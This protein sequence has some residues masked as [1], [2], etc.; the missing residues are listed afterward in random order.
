MAMP[1]G[2]PGAEVRSAS[3]RSPRCCLSFKNR[4]RS[5]CR[6]RVL[7]RVRHL[8]ATGRS[9]APGCRRRPGLI[10]YEYREEAITVAV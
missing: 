6:S 1:D 2:A 9:P 8:E 3:T 7:L 5:L 10:A 4:I